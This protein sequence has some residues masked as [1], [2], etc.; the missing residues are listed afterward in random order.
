[1]KT[2]VIRAR[3]ILSLTIHFEGMVPAGTVKA[4]KTV[5]E[6]ELFPADSRQCDFNAK[7]GS[8]LS[9]H[10]RPMRIRLMRA[11]SAPHAVIGSNTFSVS[12]RME[13]IS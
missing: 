7:T 4:F 3:D 10:T 1:M 13:T 2:P 9:S 8:L 11:E 6:R 12:F 5:L